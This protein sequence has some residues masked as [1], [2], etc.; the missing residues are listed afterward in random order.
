MQERCLLP[1][2][3]ISLAYLLK[4][5][6]RLASRVQA[7]QETAHLLPLYCIS[8]AYILKRLSRISTTERHTYALHRLA[9]RLRG[10]RE[11]ASFVMPLWGIW[12][13]SR[14]MQGQRPHKGMRSLQ[15][16]SKDIRCL[17]EDARDCIFRASLRHLSCVS[18]ACAGTRIA[19]QVSLH[20]Y[21]WHVYKHSCAYL[22]TYVIAFNVK[23]L[24]I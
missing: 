10:M 1:L 3:C 8:L 19:S 22:L 15:G 12:G 17:S 16:M 6:S 2:Y 23:T 9:S 24:A 4:I 20:S 21:A 5:L 14:E 13:I 7:R 18:L 11:T